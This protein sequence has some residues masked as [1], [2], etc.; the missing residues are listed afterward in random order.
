MGHSPDG[1]CDH[2]S[3]AKTELAF[4]AVKGCT[5]PGEQWL[6]QAAKRRPVVPRT[7]RKRT[8]DVEKLAKPV[9]ARVTLYPEGPSRPVVLA[10]ASARIRVRRNPKNEKEKSS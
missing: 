7:V 1:R 4:R 3:L 2:A 8:A 6:V 9:R 10:A 5:A